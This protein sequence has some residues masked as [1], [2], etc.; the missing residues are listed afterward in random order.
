MSCSWPRSCCVFQLTFYGPEE[1]TE[2][3]IAR[4]QHHPDDPGKATVTLGEG[5]LRYG[6]LLVLFVD[7]ESL[8]LS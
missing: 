4:V 6:F 8:A 5:V 1:Q 7:I 3:L 2:E